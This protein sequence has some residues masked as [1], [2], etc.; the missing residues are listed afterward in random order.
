MY[1][2]IHFKL[3]SIYSFLIICYYPTT[4]ACR[5]LSDRRAKCISW[6]RTAYCCCKSHQEVY[7][8]CKEN[9]L[10]RWAWFHHGNL[11]CR[12]SYCVWGSA[13]NWLYCKLSTII[14][15]WDE[16]FLICKCH[17]FLA[18]PLLF[19]FRKISSIVHTCLNLKIMLCSLVV[20][21]CMIRLT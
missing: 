8:S 16:P 3:N 14:A 18:V 20:L 12:Q 6:F 11:S 15:N 10:Y 13:F 21:V 19:S 5:H 2:P 1:T 9:S 7:S 17:C 4:T